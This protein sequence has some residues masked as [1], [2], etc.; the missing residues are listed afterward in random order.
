MRT[1]MKTSVITAFLVTLVCAVGCEDTALTPGTDFTMTLLASPSTVAVDETSTITATVLSDTGVPAQGI[2][3]LFGTTSGEL[4]PTGTGVTTNSDGNAIAHL[5]VLSTSPAETTVT[6]VSGTLTQT[7]KIT[8]GSIPVNHPPVAVIVA[9]PA[10]E[11]RIG[12]LVVFDGSTST[13]PDAG[14]SIADFHWVI[15]SSLGSS[16][17]FPYDQHGPTVSFTGIPA[18]QVLTVNLTVTDQHGLTSVAQ[19]I[20]TIRDCATNVAPVATI[21]ETDLAVHAAVGQL[22]T[23]TLH[24]SLSTDSDGTITEYLWTCGNGVAAQPPGN[25]APTVTCSYTVLPNSATYTVSL[26]VRDNCNQVSTPDS[27]TVT[28]SIP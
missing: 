20:Y 12:Q 10:T 24:G 1:M 14:D 25:T 28:A 5:K 4:T 3:V 11:Q 7:V 16:A 19:K 21:Q 9:T 26:I 8:K 13:D 17:P 18:A 23:V 6:A 2:T 27:I 15:T 22:A